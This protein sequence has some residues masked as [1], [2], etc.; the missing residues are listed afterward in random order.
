[1]GFMKGLMQKVAGFFVWQH[2]ENEIKTIYNTFHS[3]DA[4]KDGVVTEDEIRIFLDHL[5]DD[6]GTKL[7]SG[8][9]ISLRDV[10]G[11]AATIFDFIM[12]R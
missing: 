8:L 1:M 3:A 9:S 5:R 6:I 2:T 11:Y 12:K 7:D 10:R 4:N